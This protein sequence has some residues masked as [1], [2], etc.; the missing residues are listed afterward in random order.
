MTSERTEHRL[1]K[2]LK[3]LDERLGRSVLIGLLGVLL[4]FGSVCAMHVLGVPP[5]APLDEPRHIAYA[6]EVAE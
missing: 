4:S 1:T 6:I 3:T 5:F 2:F